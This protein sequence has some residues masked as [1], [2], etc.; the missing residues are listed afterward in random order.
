MSK[1]VL[2]QTHSFSCLVLYISRCWARILSFLCVTSSLFSS[3]P[4][5]SPCVMALLSN[6]S[7][8]YVAFL[9]ILNHVF[10]AAGSGLSSES[11]PGLPAPYDELY[12]RGVRAYFREDW[13]RAAEFLEKSISTRNKLLRTR[14]KCHD[15]CLTAGD[16]KMSKLGN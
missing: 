5:C 14:R 9:F 11:S 1:P 3:H 12:Y 8:V 4:S 13:E 10:T 16:D 7:P 6:T 15:E 2:K